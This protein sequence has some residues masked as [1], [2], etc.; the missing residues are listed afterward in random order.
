M[1]QAP[2]QSKRILLEKLQQFELLA[3]KNRD[4]KLERT[5][6]GELVVSPPTGWETGERNWSISGELYLWWRNGGQV[7]KGF[8]SSTGFILPNGA[9]RSPDAS[10]VSPEREV[11][12]KGFMKLCP[13]FV[14]ELRSDTDGLADLKA[15]MQEY[16]DNGAKLGWLIDPKHRRVYVYRQGRS[17]EQLENP[18]ELLGEDVVPGFVLDLRQIWG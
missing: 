18:P 3:T 15:K 8:D 9:T 16:L 10:W 7:G 13:D 17:L 1:L 2:I 5:A 14:V 11:P 4:L 12:K 6:K